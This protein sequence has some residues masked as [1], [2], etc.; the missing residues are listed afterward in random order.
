MFKMWPGL[1]QYYL[2]ITEGMFMAVAYMAGFR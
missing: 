1:S 2:M